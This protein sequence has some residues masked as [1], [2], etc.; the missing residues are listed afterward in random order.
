MTRA[1]RIIVLAVLLTVG[2]GEPPR[3]NPFDLNRCAKPCGKGERCYAGACVKDPCPENMIFVKKQTN[4]KTH[5]CIAKVE[6]SKEKSTP[7]AAS[8]APGNTPWSGVQGGEGWAACRASG[9]TL[10]SYEQW[11][12]ACEGLNAHG[13]GINQPD[14]N[15]CVSNGIRK[16]GSLPACEGGYTGLFDML[17]NVSEWVSY[18][19][20]GKNIATAHALAGRSDQGG[21]PSCQDYKTDWTNLSESDLSSAGFRCCVPCDSTG[22]KCEAQREWFQYAVR[23]G[24]NEMNTTMGVRDMWGTSTTSI[25]MV[26]DS[27]VAYYDGH[28]WKV[29]EKWGTHSTITAITG[30]AGGDVYIAADGH[31]FHSNNGSPKMLDTTGMNLQ[32]VMDIQV[33]NNGSI[34]LVGSNNEPGKPTTF[35]RSGTTWTAVP[36]MTDSLSSAW[37]DR[38][39]SALWVAGGGGVIARYKDGKWDNKR[40]KLDQDITD[41]HGTGSGYILAV[42]RVSDSMGQ[43][44][45]VVLHYNGST[46]KE[47]DAINAPAQ[48]ALTKVIAL[49]GNKFWASGSKLLSL[50][51]SG[52]YTW[53]A[54][55]FAQTVWV[56]DTSKPEEIWV[57]QT[58]RY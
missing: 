20:K 7:P 18:T 10:C 34:Y 32:Q 31:V 58:R 25:W 33:V 13:N 55:A 44:R 4:A 15:V 49:P 11:T 37:Y 6:A 47:L 24:K 14:V 51:A 2:C 3:D 28:S 30:L 9:Y 57:G 35:H 39:S 23:G 50:D 45:A 43:D 42:G 8:L 16:T 41:I 48:S 52:T 36:G 26:S 5:F 17:G 19:E 38:S 22:D 12:A 40:S 53:H 1:S 46:W 29:D 56:P 27:R 54:E 21:S